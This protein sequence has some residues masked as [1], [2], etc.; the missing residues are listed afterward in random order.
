MTLR[1]KKKN[2]QGNECITEKRLGKN[3]MWYAAGNHNN[4]VIMSHRYTQGI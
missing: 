1:N 4:I 2:A 3:K